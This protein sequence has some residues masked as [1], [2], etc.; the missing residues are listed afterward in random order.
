LGF[1]S[2]VLKSQGIPVPPNIS[3][4]KQLLRQN[5]NEI[6]KGR[7]AFANILNKEFLS[8]GVFNK[9]KLLGN[10]SALIKN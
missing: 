1:L 7:V 3:N 6:Y 8:N 10:I 5:Q 4:Y 2:T 9:Q